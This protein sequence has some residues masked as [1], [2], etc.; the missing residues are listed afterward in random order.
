MKAHILHFDLPPMISP[1]DISMKLYI[2]SLVRRKSCGYYS[3][4]LTSSIACDLDIFQSHGLHSLHQRHSYCAV[5]VIDLVVTLED[6]TSLV[7]CLEL[8]WRLKSATPVLLLNCYYYWVHYYLLLFLCFINVITF[9]FLFI[10]SYI[11]E[12][13]TLIKTINLIN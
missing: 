5:K 10:D 8:T 13:F 11:R 2:T 1:G 4:W 7:M 6:H 12:L 9:L 3:Y